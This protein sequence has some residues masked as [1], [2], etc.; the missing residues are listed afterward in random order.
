[1]GVGTGVSVAG[2]AGLES[3]GFSSAAPLVAAGST[4]AEPAGDS[5]TSSL[6][7]A[8]SFFSDAGSMIARNFRGSTLRVTESEGRLAVG[9]S[10]VVLDARM[11]PALL[12]VLPDFR[13][14]LVTVVVLVDAAMTSELLCKLPSSQCSY[15]D[16]SRRREEV[17]RQEINGG[18]VIV[19]KKLS[20]RDGAAVLMLLPQE[21]N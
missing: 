9:C 20:L 1:M 17:S 19:K 6:I 11:T 5:R 21:V 4:F 2:V 15:V 12:V 16:R 18:G 3:D 7:G 13:R 14:S 10:G 8:S